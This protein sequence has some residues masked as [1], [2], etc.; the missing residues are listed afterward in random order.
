M[1]Q[2]GRNKPTNIQ[3]NLN[4]FLLAICVG[5]SSWALYSINQLDEQIAGMLPLINANATAVSGINA[6]NKE[7]SEKIEELSARLI[8][9]ETIQSDHSPKN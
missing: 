1:E 6:V 7:Q 5:L 4:T 3:V 2:A 9:L 8:K